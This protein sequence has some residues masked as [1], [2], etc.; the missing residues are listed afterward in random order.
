M[1]G[2]YGIIGVLV[3]VILASA[4]LRLLGMIRSIG[5]GASAPAAGR[6]THRLSEGNSAPP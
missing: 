4:L 1:S 2:T 3:V 5:A 6:V